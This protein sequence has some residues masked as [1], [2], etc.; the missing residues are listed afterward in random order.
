M[1]RQSIT[2]APEIVAFVNYM[3]I[4]RNKSP[5]TAKE[6]A[7]D[8]TRFAR[9]IA[10]A[11]LVDATTAQIEAWRDALLTEGRNQPQSV[12]R[13]LAAVSSFFNWREK[14]DLLDRKNPFRAVEMPDVARPLPKVM[15]EG[16]IRTLLS[17]HV[18]HRRHAHYLETRDHAMMEVLYASGL[19][20]FELTALDLSDI[21]FD[22]KKVHVRHGKG[23]KARYS[24]LTEPAIEALQ[25]YLHLRPTMVGEHSGSA[26][27]LTISGK[28]ITPRQLW[29]VFAKI[30]EAAK[31]DGLVK[32]VVPH[33]VRHSFATHIFRRSRNIRAVQKLLG[34]SSINT[35]ERYT[36]VDDDELQELY[37]AS[38]PRA[39][40]F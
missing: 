19:R 9:F 15:S 20:R 30:R 17:A 12:R 33:T 28:R 16:E 24:F 23:D 37:E 25:K 35:T 2:Y 3:T 18:P 7:R 31:A 21:D 34:H 22:R 1:Q 14:K 27:F 29:C 6:Y 36:H 8:L 32:H 39:K 26:L 11:E 40:A 5:R 38:H 10:P 4:S 13:K